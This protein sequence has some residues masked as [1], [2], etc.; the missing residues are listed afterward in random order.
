MKRRGGKQNSFSLTL[1]LLLFFFR[2]LFNILF[3]FKLDLV[4][5]LNFLLL[6]E[7]SKSMISVMRWYDIDGLFSRNSDVFSLGVIVSTTMNRIENYG[8]GIKVLT[9]RTPVH[10]NLPSRQ[11][12]Y[13]TGGINIGI[14][15]CY[16]APAQATWLLYIENSQW[17]KWFFAA[18][19]ISTINEETMVHPRGSI[20]HFDTKIIPPCMSMELMS[21]PNVEDGIR[22]L[23]LLIYVLQLYIFVIK[24]L[25]VRCYLTD[26]WG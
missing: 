23:S 12:K 25:S 6:Y 16:F 14:G 1:H 19:N 24:F 8:K 21:N 22:T 2:S 9:A 17:G 26:T 10:A 7:I 3:W 11:A 15:E 18:S 4:T 13:V 5:C 20:K